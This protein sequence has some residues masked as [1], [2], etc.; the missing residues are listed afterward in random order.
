MTI[1]VAVRH[2]T[3]YD[4]SKPVQLSPHLIRLRPAA[5]CRSPIQSYS[6]K[7]FPEKHFLNWQQDP[8]G[9][10]VARCVFPE[11]IRHLM[12]DV[13][14]IT[15]MTVIN[16][17]D[18]FVEEYAAQWPFDY[19]NDLAEELAPYLQI[20]EKGPLL[21]QY[22]SG[23]K[24]EPAAIVEF[25]VNLNQKLQQQVNYTVRLDPGIQSCEQTLELKSG[26]CRDSAWLLVQILR[27]LG[28][29]ARF[30]SGYLVQLKPDVKSL[31]GPSGTDK[32]FSDLH[33]W[34]EVF[35]PG[36]GWLGLDPTSGL[37]AGE[38]HIPLACTPEPSSA[39]PV[40]GLADPCETEFHFENSVT[41]IYEAPRVSKPF[42]DEQW[43]EV[44]NLGD[45]VD[46]QLLKQ[47]V[48]LTQGGEPTFVSIDDRDSEQ[49]N[50]RAL[51]QHKEGLAR[52]LLTELT[53][54]FA[55]EGLL[56]HGQGKW[57]PGEELP[58]WSYNCFFRKDHEALWQDKNLLSPKAAP[59]Y[60]LAQARTFI[61]ALA[62]RLRVNEAAVAP[63]YE[64][65]AHYLHYEA[66]LP[67]D[68]DPRKMD[69]KDPLERRRFS[70]LLDQGLD[71]ATGYTLPLAWSEVKQHWY[72]APWSF[73]RGKII[74]HPGD[75]PMGYR[76]PLDS[77]PLHVQEK[78][79][80]SDRD[81]TEARAPL[82][83]LSE[84]TQRYSL[85]EPPQ[86]A[87]QGLQ[88]QS[89]SDTTDTDDQK[90][91]QVPHTALCVQAR[92]GRLWVFL[93]PLSHLEHWQE[94]I[95]ALEL[96][97]RECA[98]AID[99]EGYEP[100]T[101]HRLQKLSV[102]PDPGVIEVNIHPANSW[103]QLVSNTHELYQQARLCRLGTDKF[104]I[105]GRHT[106]TGGGNH[107]TLGGST[108]TDSPFLRRPDLLAS[109]VLYWQHHPVLSYLFSGLFIGPTSQSPRLDEAR[110]D[111]LYELEIALQQLSPGEAPE[112]WLV[113]RLFRNILV[114][115]TG[116]TH[117]AEF[118]ID[119]LYNPVGPTGRLGLLELRAFEMPPH[120][121]MSA[122]QMLLLR[123]LVA[124]FWNSPYRGRPARWGNA[125]HDRFMLPHYN[126][127]DLQRV[128]EDLSQ[129]GFV[130]ERKWFG[131]FL[132]FRFPPYGRIQ[133]Q[134]MELE[135]RAAI[136]P[137]H[138][139]GEEVTTQG[140]A[141]YVDS[142]VERLQV[143]VSGFNRERYCLAC[144]GR[145]VPLQP[146]ETEGEF[147]AGIRFKAWQPA[148][149]LHP[150]L[151]AQGPLVIDI[152][153]LANS[154][155]IGGC[156]YHVAHPSG[157]NYES[158]PVNANEAEA[159]R[160][161]RFWDHGHSAGNMLPQE[162]LP[163]PYYPCTL[164]LRY[165]RHSQ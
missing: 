160:I 36:A 16:P 138:V 134:G 140:T 66:T 44:L 104:M 90:G 99:L 25:L 50:T 129:V 64:D 107:I 39:A 63:A 26:S 20:R 49:W 142:S 126:E 86:T 48:R 100:P 78:R 158:L 133:R 141:R 131:S 55:P 18:F 152:V 127:L 42:S 165:R 91:Q 162:E 54:S 72:A 108:P 35:V 6:L 111:A 69:L 118:C 95:V 61:Q 82:S 154:K 123:S 31:D 33:A 24:R 102:T 38:G 121:Q 3:I 145:R 84:I 128:L 79:Q 12:I 76:L 47:D 98:L 113:D 77:L 75:S 159:R 109:L 23:I 105:D 21:S 101:D 92:Q 34:T 19:T 8:F 37:F 117:R 65:A 56:H 27:H 103:R 119:K 155:S 85:F 130:F 97:A 115:I 89:L 137:W 60:K 51:G 1:L 120:W 11:K 146:T 148:F 93:P 153:D 57:Y 7:I 45:Q 110:E 151:P 83:S 71:Q 70:A 41:R 80:T 124:M 2:K 143:K 157:R 30:V 52:E 81:S 147:V 94:L 156:T 139:L 5:H 125:L 74:L 88:Q 149:G 58:R 161:A 73:R 136:E 135:L 4:Y 144:N 43:H 46:E 87:V 150:R 53:K 59:G 132:E 32:D 96:T 68:I 112:P 163:N 15:E 17:F 14:L 67:S 13:E 114:D 9:N 164:D 40:T 116:N 62:R 29:A 122:L 10:F 22:L 28:L 106:G